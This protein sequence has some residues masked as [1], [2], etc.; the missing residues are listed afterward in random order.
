MIA[1][2]ALRTR[3]APISSSGPSPTFQAVVSGALPS[4]VPILTFLTRR[5]W[6]HVR[7]YILRTELQPCSPKRCSAPQHLVNATIPRADQQSHPFKWHRNCAEQSS[8]WPAPSSAPAR[9]IEQSREV[10][11]REAVLRHLMDSVQPKP[12]VSG[13]RVADPHAF[14]MV[15]PKQ[16]CRRNRGISRFR[17]ACESHARL[18]Q[19]PSAAHFAT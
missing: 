12:P 1:S 15:E 16:K 6:Y 8:P 9:P 5:K 14:G 13:W 10:R 4:E 2:I 19:P 17:I 11:Q 7:R 18:C 3:L